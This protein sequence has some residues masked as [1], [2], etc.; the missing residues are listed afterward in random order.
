MEITVNAVSFGGICGL[1]F[2]EKDTISR[3][4]FTADTHFSHK[5]I[6]KYCERPFDS[7][8]EMNRVLISKWNE[9]VSDD[10]IVIINGDFALCNRSE[11]KEYDKVL[12]GKKI[13]I[14]GSHGDKTTKAVINNMEIQY[15][16]HRMFITHD[17]KY[18][19]FQHTLNLTGHVHRLWRVAQFNKYGGFGEHGDRLPV[20]KNEI[21]Q[22]IKAVTVNAVNVGTDVWDFVPITIDE[23]LTRYRHWCEE[24]GI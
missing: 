13:Y 15:G 6:I 2:L 7:V 20:E 4:F 9:R 1:G 22:P 12:K 14:K 11:F 21:G 16:G 18:I 5:N 3:L 17:P 8:E 23:I 10:D 24:H 19:S